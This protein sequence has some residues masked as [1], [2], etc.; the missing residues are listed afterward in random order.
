MQQLDSFSSADMPTWQKTWQNKAPRNHKNK[1]KM[2]APF[3]LL[4]GCAVSLSPAAFV[5]TTEW[6]EI[7][8]GVALPPGLFVRMDLEK[9]KR[10]A[11]LIT[12]EERAADGTAKDGAYAVAVKPGGETETVNHLGQKQRQ[13]SAKKNK[14]SNN[15]KKKKSSSDGSKGGP[16]IISL[17]KEDGARATA[18]LGLGGLSSRIRS[19]S[20]N[21]TAAT[22]PVVD[23][24]KM[25]YDVLHSVL[26]EGEARAAME[27][28]R[29]SMPRAEF[30]RVL[31]S[32]WDKRQK[33]LAEA[34]ATVRDEA[35]YMQQLLDGLVGG[36]EGTD[37]EHN[38]TAVALGKRNLLE[39]VEWEVQDLDKAR[40]FRTLGGLAVVLRELGDADAGVRAAASHVIGTFAKNFG[41]AQAWALGAGTLPFLQAQLREAYEGFGGADSGGGGC[42]GN[43]PGED[44]VTSSKGGGG[45]AGSSCEVPRRAVYALGALLRQNKR[46]QAVFVANGGMDTLLRCGEHAAARRSAKLVVKVMSLATDLLQEHMAEA[47]GAAGLDDWSGGL[48]GQMAA[49][50]AANGTNGAAAAAAG[51]DDEAKE[52]LEEV[53]APVLASLRQPRWCLLPVRALVL[54]ERDNK[55]NSV[56]EKALKLM[57]RTLGHCARTFAEEPPL[58]AVAATDEAVSA[59]ATLRAAVAEWRAADVEVLDPDYRDEL[60]GLAEDVLKGTAAGAR[61]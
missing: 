51:L 55:F 59:A 11:K 14:N 26:P 45:G 53:S 37:A 20:A 56:R 16:A 50:L 47:G 46:A 43:E 13:K 10:F 34:M 23:P 58:A 40:D 44:L 3:V 9:N 28:A 33:E 36:E 18:A 60:V 17:T 32:L 42:G 31:R 1:E 39:V 29:A 15:N 38:A 2:I 21:E 25:M 35:K 7:P 61:G 8:D 30:R 12:A 41:E 19:G 6:Q 27:A 54:F 4:C 24:T 48:S 52:L 57:K 49:A 22:L 5:A